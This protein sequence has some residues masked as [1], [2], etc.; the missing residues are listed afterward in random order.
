MNTLFQS[1]AQVIELI[2]RADDN[3]E[4]I[5]LITKFKELKKARIPFYINLFELDEILRWKLRR[6]YNRQSKFRERNTDGNVRTITQAA[7][8]I[9]HYDKEYEIELRLKILITLSGVEVPV[10]SAILTLCYPDQYSVIDYRNW[11]QFFVV[12]KEKTNYTPKEY[13]KYLT[14]LKKLANEFGVTPQEIDMAIWQY[15]IELNSKRN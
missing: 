4:T 8:S 2:R 15:D 5:R 11:R 13:I 9:V 10:A 7:F 1:R 3:Y 12:E 14:I 6:Q